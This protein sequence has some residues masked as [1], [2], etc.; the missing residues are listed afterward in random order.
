[1]KTNN[2]IVNDNGVPRELKKRREKFRLNRKVFSY[3]YM[4]FLLV[5]VVLPLV[6]ILVN[7]FLVDGQLSLGNFVDFFTQKTSLQVLGNSLLVGLVT[8]LLCLIIG[9]PVALILS[10]MDS[11]KILTQGTPDQVFSQ[12]ELLKKHRL[13]VPQST[14]LANKL[15]GC[16]V[17]IDKMPLDTEACVKML[18]EVLK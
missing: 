13:D 7:A 14:E 2:L 11:G 5:F 3:P 16:G 9:Y 15:Y 8:T 17:K 10:K 12:V 6:M 1:M 4:L 18:E